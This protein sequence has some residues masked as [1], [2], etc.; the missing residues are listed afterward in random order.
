MILTRSCDIEQGRTAGLVQV[1]PL[2]HFSDAP[3]DPGQAAALRSTDCFHTVTYLPDEGG[4]PER[5]V[6]LYRAEPMQIDLLRR[7]ERET[8]LTYEATRW[9]L[10][11]LV[12]HGT[13]FH[14]DDPI[15]PPADD[16][17]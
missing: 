15:D 12:I 7:C 16:F 3:L 10:R 9:L 11:K 4:A 2:K 6:Q 5:L 1:A 13:G 8:Q 14:P 17:P